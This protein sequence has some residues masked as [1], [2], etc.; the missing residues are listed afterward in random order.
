MTERET[1]I[2]AL[3]LA[4]KAHYDAEVEEQRQTDR[5]ARRLALKAR[6]DKLIGQ[7]ALF[8][9]FPIFTE[10]DSVRDFWKINDKFKDG[11]ELSTPG[12]FGKEWTRARSSIM[13]D[14]D[15]ARRWIKLTLLRIAAVE[16]S[17]I[18]QPL[19]DHVLSEL[20]TSRDS[21]RPSRFAGISN[22]KNSTGLD[23]KDPAKISD[24]ELARLLNL[25][26]MQAFAFSDQDPG[27]YRE[28]LWSKFDE[29]NE[30]TYQG[31]L[32]PRFDAYWHQALLQVLAV[33]DLEDG[34][35]KTTAKVLEELRPHFFCGICLGRQT[36]KKSKGDVTEGM[37]ASEVVST[38]VSRF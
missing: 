19:P 4:V 1:L 24:S 10:L 37:L 26:P 15:R 14:V 34:P 11:H 29:I 3:A 18:S 17:R 12:Q 5:F 35:A 33:V 2:P 25:Y 21:R 22:Y 6:F 8:P 32:F 30:E 31:P 27:D 28:A 7:L 23:V 13:K 16:L 36:K 9:S 38:V 20:I